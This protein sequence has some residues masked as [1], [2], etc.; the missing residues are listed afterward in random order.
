MLEFILLYPIITFI[1]LLKVK[2][3]KLNI[4][5][6][7]VYGILH[8]VLA[9]YLIDGNKL[10]SSGFLSI[11]FFK[12]NINLLFLMIQSILFIFVTLY[13]IDFV[14]DKDDRWHSI[15]FSNLMMFVA[16]MDG[17]LFSNHLGLLWVFVEATTLTSAVL[18]YY[19][20]TMASLEATWK[21]I[22]ICS[23]GI[24]M[25]FVGILLLASAT[26][27]LFL[28]DLYYNALN[29][30][31][32][33][34]K[35]SFVFIIFGFGTKMGFAPMHFWL[36]DAYA[37]SPSP[38]SA[39]LSSTLLNAI[40]LAILRYYKIMTLSN[41]ADFANAILLLIGFLSVFIGAVFILKSKNFKRMF[42][43]SSIEHKGIIIIGLTLGKAGLYA[44]II[45][46]IAHS[47]T[48]F[49]IFLTTGNLVTLFKTKEIS[50]IKGLVKSYP[51][52]GWLLVFGFLGIVATPPSLTFVSEFLIIKSLFVS[53]SYF[54]AILLLFLLTVITYGLGSSVINMV[55]NKPN[56]LILNTTT[57]LS[58]LTYIPQII[59]LSALF[60]LGI[61][62]PPWLSNLITQAVNSI[63]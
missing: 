20:K 56:E 5:S 21:Y 42:A 41:N 13:S 23:I 61:Y 59:C 45:H 31:Q 33:W 50:D 55:F 28:D 47:L 60:I 63:L 19:N 12:D 6:T 38:I 1:I 49:S 7:I 39:I 44:V 51:I 27:S 25:A 37:E 24:A 35:I 29:I 26:D 57:K 34:I 8:L 54:L 62:L 18:I 14:K 36:P 40:F 16:S 9:L 30:N 10:T 3:R 2:C 53:K 32:F 52:V 43:Y 58:P 11:Y 17:V 46:I 22:F 48:K 15:Y 4:I